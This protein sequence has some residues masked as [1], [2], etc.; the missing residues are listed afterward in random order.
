MGDDPGKSIP[1]NAAGQGLTEEA[2]TSQ[3]TVILASPEFKG[4]PTLTK[5]LRYVV[6]QTLAGC[7]HQIKGFTIATQ[8]LGRKDNFDAVK[9][10]TVRILA[11]KLRT[12]LERYYL[13][14]GIK[15]PVRIEV[16]KGTYV[17][18]FLNLS[19]EQPVGRSSRAR[20]EAE[21]VCSP[22]GPSIAVMPFNN[23]SRDPEQEHF[24]DGLTEE[25]TAEI[26]RYQDFRVV[27]C[28]STMKMK[29]LRICAREVGRELNV[30]FFLEGSI[31]NEN[32]CVKI[33]VRLIDTTTQMQIWGEQYRRDFSVGSLIH[34]QEEVA[35]RVVG[36]IGGFFGVIPQRL[37]LESRG[38]PPEALESYEAFLRLHQY[39]LF[40]TEETFS[41]ALEA[42]EH[43]HRR[44]PESG[45]VW[46]MLANLYADNNTL[47]FRDLDAPMEK[48]LAYA[49]TGAALEP[50]NQYVRSMLAYLYFLVNERDGF[51]REA[52]LAME[53]NPNSPMLTGFLGWAMALYGEWDR[54]LHLL[55]Q[56]IESNPH[57]PGWFH[58]APYQRHY[59]AGRYE[60]AYRQ[61]LK[62][63]TPQLLWDPLMQAAALGQLGRS[64]EARA[65]VAELLKMK[66][67]F[68][69]C[70]RRLI[71]FFV[72][73]DDHVDGI[74]DG[75]EKAGLT[76]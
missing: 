46:A 45:V 4:K 29:G 42:L 48:A 31:R 16:P 43:A 7:A 33:A 2:I 30:R 27:A 69:T 22:V 40:L 8:V 39:T 36:K 26:A 51:F 12:A 66:P 9:D 10:P 34:L 52:E 18:V 21:A 72:K 76:I 14:F 61:A 28:H 37:A 68:P 71:G 35:A 49:R 58:M 60:E 47:W 57:Y 20:P 23:L 70:A 74:L 38:R 13:I 64:A 73:A 53:L 5:F 1:I 19:V 62:I 65:A 56:G 59:G 24:A 54:G 55:E 63:Q 32:G 41:Q 44:E 50:Q 67:D 17:P 11:G 75:L 15:D 3:L 6:E 25:L